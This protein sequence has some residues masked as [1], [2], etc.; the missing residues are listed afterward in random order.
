MAPLPGIASG[1]VLLYAIFDVA[2]EADLPAVEAILRRAAD[3][4]PAQVR[5]LQL[6]RQRSSVTFA[7]APVAL[8]LGERML[9]LGAAAHTAAV[10]AKIYDFGALTILWS[11]NIPFGTT[12]SGLLDMA[13]EVE[14]LRP[15]LDDWMRQDAVD[16]SALVVEA[17][18]A[19]ELRVTNESFTV[20]S[21]S[22]FDSDVSA[23]AL[24]DA[25][26]LHALVVGDREKLS[27]QLRDDLRATS[28]SYSDHDLV[29]IGYDHAIVYD[30][31]NAADIAALLEFALAQVLELDYYDDLLDRRISHFIDTVQASR[32]GRRH[33]RGRSNFESLRRELMLQHMD[34][35]EV[36]ERV[37]A[38]VKVTED[39]YYATVYR[40]AMR[41][42]RADEL[43]D[44]TNRKLDLMFRTYT[45]LAD[46][47]DSE[48]SQRLELIIVVLIVMEIVI[49]IVTDILR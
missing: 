48:K 33:G 32:R 37:T 7:N 29:T 43:L 9:Q 14:R 1:Q 19:P 49:T 40:A 15:Q 25:P 5:R 20:F 27:P 18:S 45:M 38:A 31:A 30:A 21:I 16:A 6:E 47:V 22:A 35:V 44:A 2:D 3:T 26:E 17:L 4:S 11:V 39:F 34:F 13:D 42:F 46:E 23:S 24:L 36:L 8:Q 12:V 28:F 41:I 10:V